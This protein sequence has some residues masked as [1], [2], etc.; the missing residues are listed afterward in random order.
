MS[1]PPRDAPRE[2]R[3]ED[4]WDRFVDDLDRA[5]QAGQA[6]TVVVP[7]TVAP[8]LGGKLFGELTR[9]DVKSLAKIAG[10]HGRRGETIVTLWDDMQKRAAGRHK[11]VRKVRPPRHKS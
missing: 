1:E 11:L 2:S 4:L 8:M 5:G 7:T 10:E 3:R 9:L 6:G